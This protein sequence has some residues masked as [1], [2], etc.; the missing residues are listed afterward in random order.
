MLL[1][2]AGSEIL[3]LQV[4]GTRGGTGPRHRIGGGPIREENR[5]RPAHASGQAGEVGTDVHIARSAGIDGLNLDRRDRQGREC[6][7]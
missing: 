6:P 3:E 7:Q 2:A 4:R 1:P 5:V